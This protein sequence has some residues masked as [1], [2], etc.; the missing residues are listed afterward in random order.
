M[1][2][3]PPSSAITR[4]IS[5]MVPIDMEGSSVVVDCESVQCTVRATK[6]SRNRNA[7]SKAG[8]TLPLVGSFR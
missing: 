3:K 8:T 7:A 1:P 6:A 4:M 2:V 5:R